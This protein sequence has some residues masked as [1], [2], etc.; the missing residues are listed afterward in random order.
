MKALIKFKEVRGDTL[1]VYINIWELNWQEQVLEEK[2][3]RET[4]IYQ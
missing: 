2:L 4:I 3:L 1:N